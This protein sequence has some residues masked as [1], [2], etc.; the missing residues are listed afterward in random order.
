[1]PCLT[2]RSTL[3]STVTDVAQGISDS[4]STNGATMIAE[5]VLMAIA[6]VLVILEAL[7][8]L[9]RV[10]NSYLDQ[11]PATVETLLQI[12]SYLTKYSGLEKEYTERYEKYVISYINGGKV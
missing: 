8:G 4:P 5:R 12:K 1:M 10:I 2:M 6:S 9:L 11:V 3:G 7:R